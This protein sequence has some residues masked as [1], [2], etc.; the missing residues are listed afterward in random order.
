MDTPQQQNKKKISQLPSQSDVTSELESP[1]KKKVK[2]LGGPVAPREMKR[3]ASQGNMPKLPIT[4]REVTNISAV[5]AEVQLLVGPG[6][7]G[8]SHNLGVPNGDPQKPLYR[9]K[10]SHD[11]LET[12]REQHEIASIA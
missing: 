1:P 6:S 5:Q 3:N 12:I 4:N 2:K 8:S 7:P 9:D 11:Y 10:N